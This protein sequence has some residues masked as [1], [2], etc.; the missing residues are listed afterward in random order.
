MLSGMGIGLGKDLVA[1]GTMRIVN[2]GATIF[3]GSDLKVL[4]V[5]SKGP[6]CFNQE[7]HRHVKATQDILISARKPAPGT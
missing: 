7:T 5:C 2:A 6:G 1:F 4:V 3:L